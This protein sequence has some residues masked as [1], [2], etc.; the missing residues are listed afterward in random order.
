LRSLSADA[1]P[2]VTHLENSPPFDGHQGKALTF[3][4]WNHRLRQPLFIVKARDATPANPRDLFEPTAEIPPPAARGTSV[5]ELY[6]FR[7]S[8]A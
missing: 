2:L 1:A 3:G 8:L 5:G 7:P 4:H 6:K